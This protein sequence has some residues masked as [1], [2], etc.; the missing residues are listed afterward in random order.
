M[1]AARA[2]SYMP[3]DYPGTR[4]ALFNMAKYSA[5]GLRQTKFINRQGKRKMK[6]VLKRSRLSILVCAALSAGLLVS[7]GVQAGG[8]TSL[9]VNAKISGTCKVTTA[10]GTLDFR[11]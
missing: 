8:T 10:P 5:I 6:A 2:C 7:N 1:Y 4:V 3:T 9:T 11:T